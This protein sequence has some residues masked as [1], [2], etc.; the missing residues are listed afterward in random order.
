MK[1][2]T[3]IFLTAVLILSSCETPGDTPVGPF[4]EGDGVYILNEGNYL[5]GNGSL[6]FYSFETSLIYND[7]FT[8]RN[9]RQLGDIPTY[10][11]TDGEKG[12]IIVNNSGTIEVVDLKTIETLG[13]VTG[14][15]SP[16][17]MVIRGHKGYISSLQSDF[18]TVLDLDKLTVDGTIDIG[19]NSEALTIY[20]ERLF[21]ANWAGGSKIAVVNLADNTVESEITTGMEPESMVL[22]KNGR[23][24]VLC[25][26]GYMNEE[27]PRIIKINATT[28]T[29]EAEMEFRT[30][31]D[32]P[33][34]LTINSGGDTLYYIDE[35]IRRMPVSMTSLPGEVLIETG[36]RLFYRLAVSRV[37]GMILVTDAIDYQQKG[38]LLVYNRKG[39]LVDTEQAGII[40]GFMRFNK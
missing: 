7:L 19:S 21:A 3:G 28:L 9:E 24:W 30:N 23:L 20:G 17:Q 10:M 37:N 18:I 2:L 25:T 11:A 4:P 1:Y 16:R 40:P 14:L 39:I 22:D 34:S 32:N 5:A 33:S 15:I 8:A 38:D 6:S 35:G 12:F 31:S 13:T 36:G 27:I 26:G 29:V